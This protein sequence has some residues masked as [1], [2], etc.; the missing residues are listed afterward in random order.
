MRVKG[1]SGWYSLVGVFAEDLTITTEK[2]EK[3]IT[4]TVKQSS[5]VFATTAFFFIVRK[6][7]QKHAARRA[8]M[9]KAAPVL[10]GSPNTFTKS[11]SV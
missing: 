7:P 5:T 10:N 1:L 3:P 6:S 11:R 4:M 2:M 9:K 8:I